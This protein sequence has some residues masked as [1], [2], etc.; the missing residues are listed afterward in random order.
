[1]LW[2]PQQNHKQYTS[3]FLNYKMILKKLETFWFQFIHTTDIFW[4]KQAIAFKLQNVQK[5][6]PQHFDFIWL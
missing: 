2:R 3:A 1:M 4:K 6:T 5:Y